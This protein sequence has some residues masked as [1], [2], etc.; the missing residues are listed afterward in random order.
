M[1]I[2]YTTSCT[3]LLW[4]F[5]YRVLKNIFGNPKPK[6]AAVEETIVAPAPS[7]PLAEPVQKVE[8]REAP[9]PVEDVEEVT[10]EVKAQEEEEPTTG[11]LCCA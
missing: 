4:L 2:T 11:M 8:A 7:A 3:Y 10:D 5:H 9:A 1:I 6:A